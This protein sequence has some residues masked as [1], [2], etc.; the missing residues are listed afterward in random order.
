MFSYNRKLQIL[1]D[2][3]NYH[4]AL[5]PKAIRTLNMIIS[6]LQNSRTMS[7]IDLLTR[8]LK[9]KD[10]L[11]EVYINLIAFKKLLEVEHLPEHEIDFMISYL[12]RTKEIYTRTKLILLELYF[13]LN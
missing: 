13:S 3:I 8:A 10:C 1:N 9:A 4:L 6:K 12:D 2:L 7:S 11:I 5:I